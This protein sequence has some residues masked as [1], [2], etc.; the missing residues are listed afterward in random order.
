MSACSAGASP[1]TP[2]A[3]LQD[4]PIFLNVFKDDIDLTEVTGCAGVGG[5]GCFGGGGCRLLRRGRP[6]PPAASPECKLCGRP[7]PAP[8]PGLHDPALWA[9]A[10]IRDPLDSFKTFNEFFYRHLKPGARPVASPEEDAVIVS[11]ADCRLVVRRFPFREPGLGLAVVFRPARGGSP[12]MP[13]DGRGGALPQATHSPTAQVYSTV[14]EAT[15]FWVKGRRFGVRSL[16]GDDAGPPDAG[17]A[18]EACRFSGGTMAIFRLAPQDYHRFHAPLGGRVLSLRHVDGQLFT[19]N[20]MAVHSE[21]ANVFTENKRDVLVLD[22]PA[23][24]AVALVAVGATLVGSIRWAVAPGDFVA[25]GDEL[26]HF[27]FGGSTVILLMPAAPGTAWDADLVAYSRK[28]LEALVRVG[29][30]I[31]AATGSGLEQ[32]GA[33]REAELTSSAAAVQDVETLEQREAGGAGVRDEE[34]LLLSMSPVATPRPGAP[35]LGD[36]RSL[37]DEMFG[38]DGDEDDGE[39]GNE[40]DGEE[41]DSEVTSYESAATDA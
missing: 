30:R 7:R 20:P 21:F 1:P 34:G 38:W 32:R 27:A 41:G 31:G 15:R 29:D 40:D 2:R 11:C 3:P 23:F 33:A 16:L 22:T 17:G 14:D 19:V 18:D 10:Q 12:C 8:C 24:G 25:K 39:E 13:S 36:G 5:W 26:G 37:H 28:S 35:A 4:I 6:A 9:A